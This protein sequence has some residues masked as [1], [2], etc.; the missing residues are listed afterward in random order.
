MCIICVFI[1]SKKK[2]KVLVQFLFIGCQTLDLKDITADHVISSVT[3]HADLLGSI[4]TDVPHGIVAV[5]RSE[6]EVSC[7]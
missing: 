6:T 4:F 2:H 1:G 7:S 3:T 5:E